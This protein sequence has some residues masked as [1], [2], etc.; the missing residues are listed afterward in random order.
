MKD[1]IRNIV[2]LLLC[3]FGGIKISLVI[4]TLYLALIT[5]KYFMKK[6]E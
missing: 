3:G 6:D 4:I 1:N 5:F 2:I